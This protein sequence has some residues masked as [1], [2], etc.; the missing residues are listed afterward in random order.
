MYLCTLYL[1]EA[2]IETTLENHEGSDGKN[3]TN[4]MSLVEKIGK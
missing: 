4:K 2:P 3:E 1:F